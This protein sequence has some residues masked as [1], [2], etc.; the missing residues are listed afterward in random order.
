M[1]KKVM[2]LDYGMGNLRSVFNA[3][4]EVGGEPFLVTSPDQLEGGKGLIIP[5]V[6][7]FGKGMEKLAPFEGVIK[8]MAGEGLPLL[9]ICLGMQ[10]MFEGS[11]EAE[12]KKGLGLLKGRVEKIPTKERL[13]HMGW[14]YVEKI[15][16]SPLLRGLEGGYAYFV[17]SYHPVPSEEEEVVATA[18]YG[19]EVCAAVWKD[20]LFGTQFH[21]E[22]SGPFGLRILKNFLGVLDAL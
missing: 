13:P 10:V 12:G 2:I 5:G 7:A 15:R 17:H 18:D 14:N 9:G 11:E 8:E 20:N 3:V 1:G 21:P 22:K 16:D 4:K 6:G 19:T